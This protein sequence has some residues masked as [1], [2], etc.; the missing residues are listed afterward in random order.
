MSA[1]LYLT[2]LDMQAGQNLVLFKLVDTNPKSTGLGLDLVNIII[3][4]VD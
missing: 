4:K 3:E 1:P 2:E